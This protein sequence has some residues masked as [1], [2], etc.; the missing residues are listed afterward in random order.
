MNWEREK[1]E[2]EEVRERNLNKGSGGIFLI[3][4][5]M[6]GD[7]LAFTSLCFTSSTDYGCW[8]FGWQYKPHED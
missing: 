8:E 5:M 4:M 7:G 6:A 2:R 1:W 3:C